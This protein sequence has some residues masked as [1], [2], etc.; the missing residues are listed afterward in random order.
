MVK[1]FH[2]LVGILDEEGF[3]D[4]GGVHAE[5]E[6][7]HHGDGAEVEGKAAVGEILQPGLA[8][9]ASRKVCKASRRASRSST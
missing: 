7:R 6:R 9:G 5:G 2:R 3:L 8:R 1:A 4:L